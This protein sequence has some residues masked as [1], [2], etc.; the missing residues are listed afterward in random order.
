MGVKANTLVTLVVLTAAVLMHEQLEM[1]SLNIGLSWTLSKMMP[2]VMQFIV[3]IL[4]SAMLSQFF[5][6]NYGRKK[7]ILIASAITLSGIAFAVH[8]IY[9]G[10]FSNSYEELI[11]KQN[12]TVFN[13]GLTMV[14]LPGCPYCYERIETLNRLKTYHKDVPITVVMVA[15]DSLTIADYREKLDKDIAVIAAPNGKQVAQVVGG[16][17]PAFIYKKQAVP[18]LYYWSQIGFGTGAMDWITEAH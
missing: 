17:F 16:S 4:L 6:A 3:I 7:L 12:T 9:E 2:Y 15:D 13:Q 10:D 14:A 11:V 1:I 8:P 5:G 18:F